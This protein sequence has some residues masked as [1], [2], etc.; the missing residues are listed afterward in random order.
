[1]SGAVSRPTACGSWSWWPSG[2]RL[3][4]L[5]GLLLQELPQVGDGLHLLELLVRQLDV[6][7]VFDRRDELDEVERIRREVALKALVHL[8]LVRV[9]AEDLRRELLQFFEIELA[10]HGQSFPPLSCCRPRQPS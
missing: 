5:G 10:C 7:L 2:L 4:P 6:V 1:M 9:D 3:Q 8:D